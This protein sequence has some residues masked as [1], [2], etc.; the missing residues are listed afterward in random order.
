MLLSRFPTLARLAGGLLDIVLP[1][2]CAVCRQRTPRQ[3]CA[4][5]AAG[6]DVSCA[7]APLRCRRCAIALP[8]Q[9]LMEDGT[10]ACRTESAT[11]RRTP[12]T[13]LC[14]QCLRHPPA[15]DGTLTLADYVTP[16]NNLMIRLK[17]HGAL[18]LAREFG[19]RLGDAIAAHHRSP[20]RNGN[21][22]AWADSTAPLLVPVPLAPSRLA[23][24]GFN[25][26]WELTRV[27]SRRARLPASANM[28]HRE[29]TTAA[30]RRLSRDERR[31]NLRGV[32]VADARVRGRH[33]VLIDDVM[34]TG[35]T[36]DAAAAALKHAGAAHVLA[37][38]ALRTP[39][40]PN[41]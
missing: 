32:F 29:R 39:P 27:A 26:A 6:F 15:F 17:Y 37:A 10:S 21:R 25:Q 28:L 13:A 38:V 2:H 34:T 11:I 5:C 40:L 20:D 4:D 16:L 23:S 31:R 33:V 30:Q 22:D 3:I 24:R 7:I 14:G 12:D 41:L 19:E 18:P 36:C 8:P 35:A 1:D 9:W